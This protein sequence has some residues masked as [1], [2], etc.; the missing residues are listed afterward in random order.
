MLFYICTFKVPPIGTWDLDHVLKSLASVQIFN[1]E[2]HCM[3]QLAILSSLAFRRQY[4]M[5]YQLLHG[6]LEGRLNN[7]LCQPSVM[8]LHQW[9]CQTSELGR[10]SLRQ[11]ACE[12][13]V[14]VQSDKRYGMCQAT[15]AM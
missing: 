11:K 2:Q 1:N 13:E 6:K 7:A 10:K 8:S 12:G 15:S 5:S 9:K 14:N 4:H 3:A